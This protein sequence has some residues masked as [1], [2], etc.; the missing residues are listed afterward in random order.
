M[1]EKLVSI[2]PGNLSKVG[3]V[4]I[5]TKEELA[6]IVRRAK[7]A[8]LGWEAL[9]FHGRRPFFNSL[10]AYL[11]DNWQEIAK[12]ISLEN[13]KPYL[14]ATLAEVY[15]VIDDIKYFAKRAQRL[16]SDAKIPIRLFKFIGKKSYMTYRP[17]GVVGIISPWNYPY[18]IPFSEVI[19]AMVAGN[20]VILKPSELTPLT[21]GKI[22]EAMDAAGFPRDVFSVIYGDG[23]TGAELVKAG[24][25][26]IIFTGSVATGKKIMAAA[27]ESL[28]PVVLELGGK[29]PMVVL[30]D[31][32]LDM[33]ARGAV[34]AAF[35][36]SGQTCASVERVYVD[37][38]I[39]SEFTE[40]VV[41]HT[42]KLRHGDRLDDHSTDVGAM[43]DERQLAI[44]ESHVADAVSKGAKVLTGGK[45]PE[46][47]KGY[48]YQPTVLD[49][50]DHRMKI[51][52]EET[53]GPCL[54]IMGFRTEEEAVRLANDSR[55]ALT[56]SV[57]SKDIGRATSIARQIVAGTVAINDHAM[58]YGIPETPWGGS[59][60]S[61]F[62][63]THS[64]IGLMEM[65]EPVHIHVDR[66]WLRRKPW[67][68]PYGDSTSRFVRAIIWLTRHL[69]FLID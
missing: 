37:E 64:T 5:T 53:F 66:G 58:T 32:D 54:P 33:A 65:V 69:G 10:A 30:K 34:W 57:W 17:V 62:G 27:A 6:E 48:F 28:T 29:D 41:G 22:Q 42:M 9:G 18:L 13:G 20:A 52:T 63:R 68:Y 44:V 47:L 26:K 51:M 15:P 61:G 35:M 67:W 16:L 14:E 8:Q 12:S 60:E 50:V 56:A 59:K 25:S 23:R 43:I 2:N 46:A 3:E 19:M 11:L 7:Q 55:Y 31:A 21:G 40:L 1:K 45:R 39:R 49:T 36:N 24:L 4:D 38:S